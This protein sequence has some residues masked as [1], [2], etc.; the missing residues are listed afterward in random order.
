[1]KIIVSEG[2]ETQS[3][4]ALSGEVD[5]DNCSEMSAS[6]SQAG[7]LSAQLIVDVSGLA[8]IDS[9]GISEL[10]RIRESMLEA[11]GSLILVKPTANVRRVLEIT[12]LTDTFGL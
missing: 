8:F 2:S 6:L 5:A 10:L 9:S 11:G 12:G 1:M 3:R 7:A 4:A